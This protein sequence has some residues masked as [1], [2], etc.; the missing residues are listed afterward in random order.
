MGIAGAATFS[1]CGAYRYDLSRGWAERP[2][3]VFIM[4]NPS[5]ASDLIDDPTIRRCIGYAKAWG[6][7]GLVVVNLFALRSTDP[8]ALYEHPEPVGADNDA[9]LARWMGHR[10]VKRVVAAW[11]AHGALA[12]RGDHV[13]QLARAAGRPLERLGLTKGGQPVHPLYQRA[14]ATLEAL[15]G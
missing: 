5:T 11:G 3:V 10:A 7:G 1:D 13:R 6:H 15:D 14:D 4:L 2:I 8:K 12:S 9:T